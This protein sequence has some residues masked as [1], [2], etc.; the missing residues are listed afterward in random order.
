M[1]TAEPAPKLASRPVRQRV[2]ADREPL[3][4]VRQEL[5]SEL[6]TSNLGRILWIHVGQPACIEAGLLR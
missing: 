1:V 6:T 5:V 4:H 3:D 2:V